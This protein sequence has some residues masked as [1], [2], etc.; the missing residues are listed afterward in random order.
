MCF[1]KKTTQIVSDFLRFNFFK[2]GKFATFSKRPKA[3]SV[4]AS[5]GV[6]GTLPPA[7]PLDPAEGSAFKPPIIGA[8]RLYLEQGLQLSNAGTVYT[9]KFRLGSSSTM[10]PWWYFCISF[11]WFVFCICSY[12]STDIIVDHKLKATPVVRLQRPS[13][14][15]V[16]I[17]FVC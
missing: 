9:P 2:L 11:L 4:S 7:L 17:F 15:F 16:R 13:K 3:K 10:M 8:S 1:L 6:W 12:L 5:G 14:T